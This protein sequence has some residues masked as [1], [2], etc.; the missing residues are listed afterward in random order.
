MEHD[1]LTQRV[2]PI[3]NARIV[4]YGKIPVVFLSEAKNLDM[5]NS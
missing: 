1:I 2:R 4:S 3:I 5:N